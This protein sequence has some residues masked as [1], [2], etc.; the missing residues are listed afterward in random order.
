[1]ITNFD[2][3]IKEDLKKIESYWF[4]E[5]NTYCSIQ[6]IK[7]HILQSEKTDKIKFILK[8]LDKYKKEEAP[9]LGPLIRRKFRVNS[10]ESLSIP[11][12]R[13]LR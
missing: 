2:Y 9:F 13:Q 3:F 5:K 4:P 10:P 8:C 12:G 7:Y 11:S 6:E 1:M